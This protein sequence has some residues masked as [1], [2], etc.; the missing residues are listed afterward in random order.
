MVILEKGEVSLNL[1]L[2]PVVV[3]SYIETLCTLTVGSV[4]KPV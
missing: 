1:T 4:K 3:V 2:T